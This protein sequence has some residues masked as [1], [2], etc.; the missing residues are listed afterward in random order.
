[1]LLVWKLMKFVNHKNV[2]LRWAT[3]WDDCCGGG[4]WCILLCVVLHT[5]NYWDWLICS[6][7]VCLELCV[8]YNVEL[9][10]CLII[11][12]FV[13]HKFEN[14]EHNSG[15]E[16]YSS[17]IETEIL[18]MNVTFKWTERII[19]VVATDSRSTEQYWQSC[20]HVLA[21]AVQIGSDILF[22]NLSGINK[23]SCSSWYPL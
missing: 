21:V 13:V 18:A 16:L 5:L 2:K 11:I 3:F 22:K 6:P 14:W 12:V 1:M 10:Q 4:C 20:W 17:H 9:T 7:V 19:I 23:W 8:C 15:C